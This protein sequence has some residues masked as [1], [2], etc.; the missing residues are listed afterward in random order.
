MATGKTIRKQMKRRLCA[1]CQQQ[2]QWQQVSH[3]FE[4]EGLRVRISGIP[5]IH[6]Q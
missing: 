6:Q 3:E 4:R 2:T 5:A 1:D